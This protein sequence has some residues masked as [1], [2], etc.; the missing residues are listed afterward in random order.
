M[1]QP[2]S[3]LL[4]YD[5]PQLKHESEPKRGPELEPQ[6]ESQS[7]L[8]HVDKHEHDLNQEV[9]SDNRLTT[10][11]Q[12]TLVPPSK[13]TEV[14]VTEPT[15]SLPKH[16]LNL[17]KTSTI[18]QQEMIQKLIVEPSQSKETYE[19]I[20]TNQSKSIQ[21]F[22]LVGEPY[23]LFLDYDDSHEEIVTT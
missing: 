6:P 2:K 11:H 20:K 23:D 13:P 5:P 4:Q 12:K 22:T 19:Y 17:N 3:K 9:T 8:E 16:K 10:I 14:A 1:Q 7:E 18:K 21:G 15:S